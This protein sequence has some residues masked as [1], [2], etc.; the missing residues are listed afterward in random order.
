MLLLLLDPA[1]PPLT[2]LNS[3]IPRPLAL[4]VLAL[5]LGVGLGELKLCLGASAVQARCLGGVDSLAA[6]LGVDFL[7]VYFCGFFLRLGWLAGG[8]GRRGGTGRGT[9]RPLRAFQRSKRSCV[10][11]SGAPSAA[12]VV[13]VVVSPGGEVS[14]L[15]STWFSFER[16][17]S[18][19]AAED[20]P[21]GAF[22]LGIIS[23]I[24]GC[25]MWGFCGF[26]VEGRG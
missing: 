22:L 11:L 25:L 9:A 23:V 7:A 13:V 21:D 24:C 20:S 26:C 5:V 1:V 8:F 16:R 10:L 12:W 18:W 6:A 14:V 19:S 4:K 2:L 3:P 17:G 15:D